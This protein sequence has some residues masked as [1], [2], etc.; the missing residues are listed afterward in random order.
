[1]N[2]RIGIGY[3]VH[4]LEDKE[5]LILG[6]VN[7]PHERGTVAHSDG[8]ALVHAIVDAI[9]GACALGDIGT[10]FP[11]SDDEFKNVDSL[12]LLRKTISICKC[13]IV[14][15]DSNILLQRP[16]LSPF[17]YKMRESISFVCGVD[18]GVVSVKAKTGERLGDVGE[19]RSVEAH[20]VVLVDIMEGAL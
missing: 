11:D 1:M 15:I 6:G 3:D 19:E 13:K 4:R 8:D 2:F 9:L 12:E 17:I 10:H 7:I 14:N 20:A 5:S 16:R 18:V